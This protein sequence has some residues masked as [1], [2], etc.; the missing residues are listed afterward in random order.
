LFLN[1]KG[2]LTV[3]ANSFQDIS[4]FYDNIF[5]EVKAAKAATWHALAVG[6]IETR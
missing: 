6:G 5:P 4:A 2:F 1:L 3:F